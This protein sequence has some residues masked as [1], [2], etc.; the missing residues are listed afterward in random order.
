MS[1]LSRLGSK[2][3]SSYPTV[4]KANTWQTSSPGE[5]LW[6]I[7]SRSSH[8]AVQQYRASGH[9]SAGLLQ[10]VLRAH[11]A[12]T[13]ELNH[14][15]ARHKQH[16]GQHLGRVAR[17]WAAFEQNI[18][19]VGSSLSVSASGQKLLASVLPFAIVSQLFPWRFQCLAL[20][21]QFGLP[22][23]IPEPPPRSAAL[24]F[25][26]HDVAVAGMK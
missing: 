4:S 8:T 18:A 15:L 13:L 25:L 3:L 9:S 24:I 22:P 26:H 1:Y 16:L 21:P 7:S 10:H 6:A 23:R 5:L 2:C 14:F 12:R 17:R 20:E 11:A 19:A